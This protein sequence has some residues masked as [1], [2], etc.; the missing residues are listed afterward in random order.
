MSLIRQSYIDLNHIIKIS[1]KNWKIW[2]KD[3]SVIK[4]VTLIVIFSNDPWQKYRELFYFTKTG[5]VFS[6]SKFW[7]WKR[8]FI[9]N[10]FELLLVK[11]CLIVSP[12]S[13]ACIIKIPHAYNF[14]Y[15]QKLNKP[16]GKNV[17]EFYPLDHEK[18]G[19]FYYLHF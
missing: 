6:W 16:T 5:K 10:Y 3:F 8:S 17:S 19:L 1:L 4:G 7:L 18:K 14:S 13:F 2:I 9:Y 12:Y 15:F 11:K